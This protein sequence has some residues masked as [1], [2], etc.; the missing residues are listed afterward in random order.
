MTMSKFIIPGL[1]AAALT[2]ALALPGTAGA[3]DRRADGVNNT[4][5][6]A[7]EFSSRHRGVRHRRV[8]RRYYYAPRPY[9][10]P[11]GPYY[12]YGYGYPYYPYAYAPRP[13]VGVGVGPFGFGVW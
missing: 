7:T 3:A 5:Q 11:W 8:V 6:Q 9:Y 2:L 4:P 13:F 1:A 12:G 10:R